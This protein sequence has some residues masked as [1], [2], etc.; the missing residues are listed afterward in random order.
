MDWRSLLPDPRKRE[1][2]LSIASGGPTWRDLQWYGDLLGL[3]FLVFLLAGRTTSPSAV[4]SSPQ[5]DHVPGRD[6][7]VLVV[8]GLVPAVALRRGPA[9]AGDALGAFFI[10][11]ST[12]LVMARAS[13]LGLFAKSGLPAHARQSERPGGGS[14]A[15]NW[16]RPRSRCSASPA[17]RP[18]CPRPPSSAGFCWPRCCC[19]RRSA[20][21]P[22]RLTAGPPSAPR[23][24]SGCGSAGRVSSA[25]TGR[26]SPPAWPPAAWWRCSAW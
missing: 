10:W 16:A 26:R 3:I 12:S 25:A 6:V 2:H 1:N 11:Q 19:S 7:P 23:C 22:R 14:T 24:R 13:V 8:L 20:W 5:P 18:C 15:A 9:P 17:S 4:T 21:P